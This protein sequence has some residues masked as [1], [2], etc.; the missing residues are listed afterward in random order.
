MRYVAALV[1]VFSNIALSDQ[2][3]VVSELHQAF[4]HIRSPDIETQVDA[5]KVLGKELHDWKAQRPDGT[6]NSQIIDILLSTPLADKRALKALYKAF[7]KTGYHQLLSSDRIQADSEERGILQ[8]FNYAISVYA[9]EAN[10]DPDTKV[11]V[12]AI[13]ELSRFFDQPFPSA[14]HLWQVMV[15]LTNADFSEPETKAALLAALRKAELFQFH[16][17]PVR[18][19]GQMDVVETPKEEA[20]RI[21][22]MAL[23][24]QI[25]LAAKEVRAASK[26]KCNILL[27]W[28]NTSSMK[29]KH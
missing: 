8:I 14:E 24:I 1:L 17:T 28:A 18:L 22:L 16:G 2:P 6:T 5:I 19:P 27:E 11:R 9:G 3:Q 20:N 12:E 21:A 23:D 26:G 29:F 13:N 15:G 7:P 4:A 10:S 25:S